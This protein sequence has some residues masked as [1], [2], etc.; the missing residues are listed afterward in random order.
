[1]S[2]CA[3]CDPTQYGRDRVGV[4]TCPDCAAFM[5]AECG[6]RTNPAERLAGDDPETVAVCLACRARSGAVTVTRVEFL[7]VREWFDA[8]RGSTYSSCRV[9]CRLSDDTRLLIT[10]PYWY[11]HGTETALRNAWE[12]LRESGRVFG[13]AP[14]LHPLDLFDVARVERRKDLHSGGRYTGGAWGEVRVL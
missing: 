4:F 11:G 12:F 3:D 7:S 6:T 8:Y 2:L 14:N 9:W 13:I 5:C 10:L 1:M